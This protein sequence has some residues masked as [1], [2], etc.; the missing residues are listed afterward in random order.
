MPPFRTA[1]TLAL[2]AF[3]LPG[4]V[5]AQTPMA[6]PLNPGRPPYVQPPYTPKPARPTP[7]GHRPPGYRPGTN[8]RYPVLI[9]GSVVNRYLATPSPKPTP[10]H[11]PAA[12]KPANGQDQFET[13]SST[14]ANE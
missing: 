3:A 6:A 4:A 1:F 2:A 5:V 10:T 13:H 7:P 12:H 9:D 8:G 14:D 11:K